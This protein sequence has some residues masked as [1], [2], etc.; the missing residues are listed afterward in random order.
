MP[1]DATDD[2]DSIGAE[3]VVTGVSLDSQVGKA[4]GSGIEAALDGTAHGGFRNAVVGED[5]GLAFGGARSVASHGG[6]HKRLQAGGAEVIT[7]GADND[8]DVGDATA[9]GTDRYGGPGWEG[10]GEATGG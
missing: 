9:A 1:F 10:G 8:G 2:E 7:D 5:A 3:G 6:E 4:E